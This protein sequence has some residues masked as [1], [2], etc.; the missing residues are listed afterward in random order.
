MF[1]STF[2]KVHSLF[3]F[4]FFAI[5][6]RTFSPTYIQ[7]HTQRLLSLSIRHVYAFMYQTINSVKISKSSKS[8]SKSSLF[9]SSKLTTDE[10]F[11]LCNH[12]LFAQQPAKLYRENTTC[13]RAKEIQK[14]QLI[15]SGMV[16]RR[17][18]AISASFSAASR[19]R[20]PH[21]YFFML[22]LQ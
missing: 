22:M 9:G 3:V 17:F 6:N 21:L 16:G 13:T 2:S 8:F 11:S 18:A 10:N 5:C 15:A 19:V 4:V 14:K 20:T 7:L 1:F 12:S